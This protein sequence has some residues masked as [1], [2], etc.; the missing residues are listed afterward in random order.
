MTDL[1]G[2]PQEGWTVTGPPTNVNSPFGRATRFNGSTNWISIPDTIETRFDVGTQDFSSIVAVLISSNAHPCYILDKRDNND[3]GWRFL[4]LASGQVVASINAIDILSTVG[5][6]VL[7]TWIIIGF[8]INRAGNGQM[9]V[10]GSP[11]GAPVA[12]GGMAMS[13]TTPL[14]IGRRS[15]ADSDERLEGDLSTVLLFRR[16][17]SNNEHLDIYNQMI[18]AKL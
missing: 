10:N 8:S 14:Y 7:D 4:V 9:Y 13:T 17:L 6:V 5:V 2:M 16:S 1:S 12:I 11:S 18:G 15:Y 3:D